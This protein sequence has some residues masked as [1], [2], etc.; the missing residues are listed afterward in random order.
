MAE[1]LSNTAL[2][3]ESKTIQIDDLV[4]LHFDYLYRYAYRYFR[5]EDKA[6]DLVQETFLAAT[7]A[8]KRFEGN[9]SPRTWLTSILRHKI[10]D[11][12]RVK[13]R[14]EIVDFGSMEQESLSKLFNEAEHWHT[15]TGPLLWGDAP[16]KTLNQKQF[17]VVLESCLG[18][19][20]RQ[21]REIFLLREM[22]GFDRDEI[23]QKVN[24]ASSNVGVIL[25]R[26]RLSLQHCLQINWFCETKRI[27][28]VTV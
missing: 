27:G 16:D 23:C 28:G 8:I 4:E 6:E 24:L 12:L 22:E 18:K 20:P 10:M 11:K 1:N 26:A 14:E 17:L 5:S 19:L 15:E 13:D 7:E 21:V 25:H 9:C 3:V 2:K